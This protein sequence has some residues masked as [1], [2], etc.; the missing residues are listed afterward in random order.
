MRRIKREE[1][2]GC[3]KGNWDEGKPEGDRTLGREITREEKKMKE[4]LDWQVNK[5][6]K[7][8]KKQGNINRR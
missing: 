2:K 5:D 4:R 1:R 6:I 7:N 8:G 3:L